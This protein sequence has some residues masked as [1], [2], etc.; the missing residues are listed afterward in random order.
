MVDPRS[1]L[2]DSRSSILDLRHSLV[3]YPALFMLLI[4]VAIVAGVFWVGADSGLAER[5]ADSRGDPGPASRSAIWSGTWT[6]IRAHPVLGVGLGAFETV[7]PI[8]GRG[9]GTS[10][11]QFAHN[12]YLQA[13]ADG[14]IVAAALAAWF[15]IVTFRGFV[16]GV[17]LRDPLL[18]ALALGAGA[19]I[20]AILVHS[21]FDFNLQLPSNALLFLVLTAVVGTTTA[22]RRR[23]ANDSR[24]MTD[25]GLRD[26]LSVS[27][28]SL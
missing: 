15:I 1:S 11:I 18:R 24:Q 7:Y 2:L 3:S 21:L 22:D 23:T 20:F 27:I 17:R 25:G 14:G 16:R 19:G 6:M 26:R 9:D 28:R 8:Y 13:L 4:T 5:L 10:L 12:D